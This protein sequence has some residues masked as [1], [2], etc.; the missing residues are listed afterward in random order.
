MPTLDEFIGVLVL[1][2]LVAIIYS[3][4]KKWIGWKNLFLILIVIGGF[5]QL[6]I[7]ISEKF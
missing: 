3:M 7:W 1:V 2:G 6:G 5:V 4:Y